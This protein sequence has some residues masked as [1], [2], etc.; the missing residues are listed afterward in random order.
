M[1]HVSVNKMTTRVNHNKKNINKKN[2]KNEWLS[3]GQPLLSN[4]GGRTPP[5]EMA[6]GGMWLPPRARGGLQATSRHFGV[7]ARHPWPPLGVA[8]WVA[9]QLAAPSPLF[10]LFNFCYLKNNN[11]LSFIYLCF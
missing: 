8:A 1:R 10:F 2:L 4:G 6:G 3:V 11:F 7:A 5:P 9:T